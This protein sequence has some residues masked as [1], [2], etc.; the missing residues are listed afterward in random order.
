M[1]IRLTLHKRHINKDLWILGERIEALKID[2]K[3]NEHG[4]YT[5]VY[6]KGSDVPFQVSET[7]E[8]IMEILKNV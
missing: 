2:I 1:F 6:T 7:P 5:S 3:R 8:E 4:Y